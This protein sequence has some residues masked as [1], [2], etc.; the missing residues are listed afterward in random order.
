MSD[1]DWH[2][3]AEPTTEAAAQIL[4]GLLQS[5]AIPARIKANIPVPGLGIAFRVEVATG[6]VPKARDVLRNAQVSEEELAQ[7]AVNSPPAE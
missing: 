3:V 4:L 6:F 2:V 5:E 7:L 1:Q